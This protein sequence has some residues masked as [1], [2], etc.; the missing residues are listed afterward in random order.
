MSAYRLSKQADN[1]IESIT[2][3]T[4]GKWG[5]AQVKKYVGGLIACFHDIA[6]NEHIGRDASEFAENLSRFAYQSHI[7]FF[8]RDTDAVLIVRVLHRSMDF[9]RHLEEE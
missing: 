7:I 9:G 8:V 4:L 6:K 1:D 2:E 5:V 3:Y